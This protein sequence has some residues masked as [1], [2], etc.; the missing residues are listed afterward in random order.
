[1]SRT[2]ARRQAQHYTEGHCRSRT[3]MSSVSWAGYERVKC[4]EQRRNKYLHSTGHFTPQNRPYAPVG[5]AWDLK[6]SQSGKEDMPLIMQQ[7]TKTEREK[8]LTSPEVPI[9]DLEGYEVKLGSYDEALLQVTPRR[10]DMHM[11]HCMSWE[12]SQ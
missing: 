12:C 7:K 2:Q 1:M 5:E 4:A 8:I 3:M 10:A 11:R 9:N 6:M